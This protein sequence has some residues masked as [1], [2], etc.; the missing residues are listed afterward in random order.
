[1]NAKL[2]T[3]TDP[4]MVHDLTAWPPWRQF[5]PPC[6]SDVAS[7]VSCAG[8]HSSRAR[9]SGSWATCAARQF[10][11]HL[12]MEFIGSCGCRRVNQ[13]GAA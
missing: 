3:L 8:R 12:K 4:I 11:T 10:Y 6:V 1:M 13:D 5:V 2:T 7:N 9:R